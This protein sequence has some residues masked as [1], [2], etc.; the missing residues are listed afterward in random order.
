MRKIKLL[1]KRIGCHRAIKIT[2]VVMMG[3]FLL[4]I[5]FPVKAENF[6]NH[7][8]QLTVPFGPG[9]GTDLV[10]RAIQPYVNKTLGVSLMIENVPGAD[11]RIGLTKIHQANPNGYAIGIHG[12]PAPLINEMLYGL[13]FKASDFTF[14]YAWTMNPQ[15]IFVPEGTW[16]TFD[17]FLVEAQKRPIIMGMPGMGTVSHLM[18]L[19]LEKHMKL[20]FNYVPYSGS[21]EALTALAGKHIDAT[22]SSTDAALSLTRAKKIRPI[23]SCAFNPDPNFPEVPLSTKYHIPTVVMTR[24]VF[25]PPKISGD[26]VRIL[27]KAFSRAATEPKL[28]EWAK[29]RGMEFVSL[30]GKQYQDVV[31]KQQ[32]LLREFKDVFKAP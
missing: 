9:S 23:I 28:M 2:I 32:V 25:G 10:A 12:F 1:R 4:M 19:M 16:K 21:A 8:V 14:I 13:P 30:N 29:S 5:A 15:L 24:G 20:K 31:D 27:E 26:K 22:F 18:A 11:S 6:P 7:P 3:L 17:E